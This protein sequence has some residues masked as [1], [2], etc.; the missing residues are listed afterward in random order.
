MKEHDAECQGRAKMD[1]DDYRSPAMKELAS[2]VFGI[3]GAERTDR[4][5]IREAT[6]YIW[7]LKAEC[8]QWQAFCND[9]KKAN[10]NDVTPQMLAAG[11]DAFDRAH[12]AEGVPSHALESAFQAMLSAARKPPQD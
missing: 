4:E 2:L 7:N 12:T 9:L 3:Q 8:I 1:A 11:L 5:V 10:Q 6:R